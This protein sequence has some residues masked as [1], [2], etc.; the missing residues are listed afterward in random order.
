MA[1]QSLQY[2]YR[3]YFNDK[4]PTYITLPDEAKFKKLVVDEIVVNVTGFFNNQILASSFNLQNQPNS[5]ES[6]NSRSNNHQIGDRTYND[7]E[8]NNPYVSRVNTSKYGNY[9][10]NLGT[11][12]NV[13]FFDSN[14]DTNFNIDSNFDNVT[15]T[16]IQLDNNKYVVGGSFTSYNS[17]ITNRI[18]SLNQ[19]ASLFQS[20]DPGFDGDVTVLTKQYIG[21]S[22]K[23]ICGGK[24]TTYNSS[25]YNN[26]VR[27]NSDLTID[28]DFI[29]D[30]GFD[31][32]IRTVVVTSDN[33]IL[34]GG[35]FTTYNT[36][37]YNNIIRLNTD[38]TIDTTFVIGSGLDNIVQFIL[39][40]SDNKILVGGNFT[41]YNGVV[42]G[43]I[44]RLN[45]D[46]S[47][48]GSFIQGKG[49]DNSVLTIVET[50]DNEYIV[51]GSFTIYDGYD[52]N[53]IARLKNDGSFDNTFESGKA[54]NNTINKILIDNQG[55]Y[56]VG[57]FFDSYNGKGVYNLC[58][59]LDNGK[60]D[61]TFVTNILNNTVTDMIFDSRN[62]LILA[63]DFT[64]YYNYSQ[65]YLLRLKYNDSPG[66]IL[67]NKSKTVSLK[68]NITLD[69]GGNITLFDL[70]D[71][72]N[73][74]TNEI[75]YQATIGTNLIVIYSLSNT[76]K[77]VII[78]GPVNGNGNSMSYSTITKNTQ[79]IGLTNPADFGTTFELN[80]V[81]ELKLM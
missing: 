36:V 81:A 63:G 47:L 33:K 2:N 73:Y 48:D 9:Y 23:I 53:R 31:G 20:S 41:S 64:Y 46:G 78:Q 13:N 70:I 66:W 16:V 26:I 49:F 55:K 80:I 35:S 6:L 10:G 24:F 71:S 54:F 56:I 43:N 19:N 18:V 77:S 39:L 12:F 34:V 67:S 14:L 17:I 8:Y 44:V 4:K 60:L 45:T 27:L 72:N 59:L 52:C 5:I 21:N 3:N 11:N 62:R 76:V 28:T 1:M 58:R 29:V 51:G 15:K 75:N 42:V 22:E 37:N 61:K 38:G 25:S 74:D 50:W 7:S 68:F 32:S 79:I 69:G 65:S 57:G 30:L 40:T